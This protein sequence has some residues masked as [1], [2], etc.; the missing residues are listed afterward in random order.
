MNLAHYWAAILFIVCVF[1]WIG[2]PNAVLDLP[3]NLTMCEP[4]LG[5]VGG[6]NRLFY[7]RE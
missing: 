4:I 2:N 1:I 3:A 5:L 7:A 6:P